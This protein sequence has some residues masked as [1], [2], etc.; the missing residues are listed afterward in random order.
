MSQAGFHL[1]G[2]SALSEHTHTP[3]RGMT[4]GRQETENTLLLLLSLS[5]PNPDPVN[6]HLFQELKVGLQ[7]AQFVSVEGS[8]AP[9]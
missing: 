8:E 7:R 5:P 9:G 1:V 4:S 6:Y 2:E 3:W